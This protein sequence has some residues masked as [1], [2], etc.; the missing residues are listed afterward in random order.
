MLPRILSTVYRLPF[1]EWKISGRIAVAIRIGHPILGQT[2]NGL[3]D[4]KGH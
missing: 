1:A 3:G 2:G 4:E